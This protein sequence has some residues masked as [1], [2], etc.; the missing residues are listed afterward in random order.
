M[1]IFFNSQYSIEDLEQFRDEQGFI[2]LTKAGVEFTEETREETGNLDRV[3][4]WVNFQGTKALVKGEAIRDEEKNYGIY[5]ELVVEEVAK[6]VGQRTAHYDLIKFIGEDGEYHLGVL[7]VSMMESSNERLVTLH[8]IIGD[9]PEETSDFIDTTSYDFTI[10]K[11]EEELQKDG[12]SEEDI[13]EVITEY[14]KRLIF[15]LAVLETDQHTENIAFKIKKVEGRNA[16]ELSPNYD[17]ESSFLLDSDI[18]TIEKLLE[19]Y[20]G[21]RESVDRAHPRIGTL[22]SIE[23]GGFDS[24]WKDTLEA[25][26]EDDEIYDYYQENIRGIVDIEKIIERVEQR[27]KAPL[28]EDI[29]LLVKHSYQIRNEQIEKIMDGEMTVETQ[30]DVSALLKMLVSQ[31][32][33][34]GIRTGEQMQV[35]RTI[36]KD[37]LEI[38]KNGINQARDENE[39]ITL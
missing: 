26:C 6:A 36:Q 38:G 25:L 19:D 24:Y 27:I 16:I 11:L 31:G 37:M 28:P 29:R 3:K 23:D 1:S 15:L 17:S 7:S 18:S 14:R 20:E 33:R 9:E 34:T 13:T 39:D 35:G 10:E 5:A 12:Y 8:D 21:L 22:K 4:N 32:V 2:D 30:V